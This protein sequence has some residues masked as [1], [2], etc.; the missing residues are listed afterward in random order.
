MPPIQPFFAPGQVP[1]CR[2]AETCLSTRRNCKSPTS[3]DPILTIA[4]GH[5]LRTHTHVHTSA[6]LAAQ[7]FASLEE[8]FAR[9]LTRFRVPLVIESASVLSRG[10][11]PLNVPIAG[12]VILRRFLCRRAITSG[13]HFVTP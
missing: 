8:Q 12:Y 3:G 13:G 4:R 1:S 11:Y 2:T 7:Q 10:M 5:A 9:F 6:L